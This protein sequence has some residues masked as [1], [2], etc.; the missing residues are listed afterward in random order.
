MIKNSRTLIAIVLL[1]AFTPAVG[2]WTSLT[3]TP[4]TITSVRSMV[5]VGTDLYAVSYPNGVKKSTNGGTAWTPVNTGLPMAGSSVFAQ[6]VGWNG[7]YLFCGTHSGVYRSNDG[8]ASWSAANGTLLASGTVYANKWFTDTGVTMAIFSSSVSLGGGIWRTTDNGNNWY[9]GH[10]GMGSNVTVYAITVVGADLWAATS[11]GIYTSADNGLNWT[12]HAVVN[13]ATFGIAVSGANFVIL[14]NA[15]YKYS[16][17][18]GAS[19]NDATGDPAAPSAGELVVYDGV[20]Y[21]NTRSSTGCLR[22]TDNGMTWSAYNTGIGAVDQTALEEFLTAGTKLY[23]TAL[24]DIYYINGIGTVTPTGE[25]ASVK[26][27]TYPTVFHDLFSVEAPENAR[28]IELMDAAGRMV[29]SCIIRSGVNTI[30]RG[31]LIAGA[32]RA[33]LV[34]ADGSTIPAGTLIAR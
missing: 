28:S 16:S 8:G 30:Q 32:Y 19:W 22:S 31:P 10:S 23:V 25:A 24:F 20:A 29:L 5:A 21:A 33:C 34:L 12:I 13:Y 4:S 11:V 27:R 1:L 3:G 7:S 2:Q 18:G 26:A 17:N 9:I 6:S 15:G 14:A